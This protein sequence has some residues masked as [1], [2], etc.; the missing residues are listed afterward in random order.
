[1]III[2]SLAAAGI[3]GLKALEAWM[4]GGVEDEEFDNYDTEVSYDGL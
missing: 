4:N 1:M 2:F 3:A